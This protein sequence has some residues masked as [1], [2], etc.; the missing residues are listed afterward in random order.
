[1]RGNLKVT[2]GETDLADKWRTDY[3]INVPSCQARRVRGALGATS[4]RLGAALSP[5]S[6]LAFAN[7]TAEGCH[8]TAPRAWRA[9]SLPLALSAWYLVTIE[10]SPME[11]MGSRPRVMLDPRPT[12]ATCIT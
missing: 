5:F 1:M 12:P 3:Y 9:R 7:T 6:G 8:R 2:S 4:A 10:P 11:V